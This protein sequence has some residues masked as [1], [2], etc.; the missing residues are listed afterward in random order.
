MVKARVLGYL[1]QDVKYSVLVQ[2]AVSECHRLEAYKQQKCPIV[3]EA[4]CLRSGGS[5]WQGSGEGPPPGYK[6][7]ACHSDFTG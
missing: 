4:G 1:N 2:A 7:P 6:L 5:V 3:V